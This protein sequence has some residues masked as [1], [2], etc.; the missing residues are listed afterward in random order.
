MQALCIPVEL[1]RSSSLH[2]L[3]LGGASSVVRP[4]S[5][6]NVGERSVISLSEDEESS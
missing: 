2:E 5:S 6:R 1:V 3:A 4:V